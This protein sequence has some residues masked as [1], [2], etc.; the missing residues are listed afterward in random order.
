LQSEVRRNV[1]LSDPCQRG[2]R[3]QIALLRG[4]LACACAAAL[5]AGD[6]RRVR[7]DAMALW[8]IVHTQ[9]VPNYANTGRP[10][11]CEAVWPD[12]AVLKDLVGVAQFLLIATTRLDGIESP[13]LLAPQAPNYWAAAWE[14]R[15]FVAQR[16]HTTLPRDAIGLA[17]NSAAARTQNQFHIHI[18]CVR[19]DVIAALHEH[20]AEIGTSWA[21]FTIPPGRAYLIRRLEQETLAHRDPF[22][23]VAA[24]G[25]DARNNMA[26]QTIAVIGAAFENGKPGFYVLSHRADVAACDPGAAEELLDHDCRVA[27]HLRPDS[28]PPSDARP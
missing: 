27:T 15:K 25:P 19:E 11:P 13:S 28:S 20:Q 17:I 6:A 10:D 22:G 14:A 4:S 23:L 26:M 1:P 16:L 7:I 3:I 8:K 5:L 2:R 9:C 12:G 24:Q 18:D 21:S